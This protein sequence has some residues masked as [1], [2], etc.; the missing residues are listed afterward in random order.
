MLTFR[1]RGARGKAEMGWLSS[2]HSFSFGHY[3]DPRHMGF[4]ALRVINE[5][6]VVPG[7]GFP[8]HGHA[9]MEIISYV[10]EGALEHKDSLGTGAV[11]RP[12]ELQR[13]S[14]GTGV[15]HSE[16]NASDR[17]SLHFLQIWIVPDRQGIE[18]DY[19]QKA[20]PPVAE[21]ESR[22]DLIG[23]P[24]GRD[25]S[26]TIH[27]DVLLYRAVLADGGALTVPLAPGRHA[28]VQVARGTAEVE[29]GEL[30]EGDGLAVSDSAT[31][32]I[33]TRTGGELL[34]FDLA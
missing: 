22:L 19:E 32:Q 18:P 21:G 24:D 29:G 28:W 5:D 4:R 20:L 30:R 26:V 16:F 10:L 3:R 15:E 34:V 1:D 31:L 7:A 12:G 13:M 6:R 27:Q 33:T 25:G 14:A 11:V 23:S 17:D 8:T 9:D 2:R